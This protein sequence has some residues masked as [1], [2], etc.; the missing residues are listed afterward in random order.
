MS[1]ISIKKKGLICACLI[2]CFCFSISNLM[3]VKAEMS[4]EVPVTYIHDDVNEYI[5]TVNSKGPGEVRYG[6]VSVRD[7]EKKFVLL[8][9]NTMQLTLKA[10]NDAQIKS[11]HL[12]GHDVTSTIKNNV[13]TI[14]GNYS[15]QS[16]NV[17]FNSI[18]TN[19]IP[20]TGD[21]TNLGRYIA[22]ILAASGVLVVLYSKKK[23]EESEVKDD[24][25]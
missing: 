22:L 2:F 24:E 6:T 16:L 5:V 13:I 19:E 3:S 25:K 9:E 12:N 20:Q 7:R 1:F 17:V 18:K 11:V 10:D 15:N 21:K 23:K 8:D 4:G 14:K